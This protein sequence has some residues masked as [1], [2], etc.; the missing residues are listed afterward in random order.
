MRKI[1]ISKGRTQE[2][3]EYFRK[4]EDDINAARAA[5]HAEIPKYQ[6]NPWAAAINPPMSVK[7][8]K[9]LVANIKKHGLREKITLYQGTILD[10]WWRYMACFEACIHPVFEE[11]KDEDPIEHIKRK[12]QSWRIIDPR[13]P[14]CAAR[15]YRLKQKLNPPNGGTTVEQVSADW[16]ASKRNVERALAVLEHGAQKIIEALDEGAI[17]LGWAESIIKYPHQGQML[18]LV[19][20]MDKKRERKRKETP[21]PWDLLLPPK[22]TIELTEE[23]AS[24][25]RLL[26]KDAGVD[27][28]SQ[29]V[30]QMYLK[31]IGE[32][33]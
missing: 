18:M 10:G 3:K 2:D 8:F 29:F 19:D 24:R 11:L 9:R 33:K 23:Q 32:V 16:N 27:D 7:D 22:I 1:I 31:A 4:L 30:L 20:Q 25:T 14:L 12:N 6:L 21:C 28:I 15:E 17:R 13:R 5:V 26:M